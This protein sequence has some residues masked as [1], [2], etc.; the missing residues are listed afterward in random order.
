MRFW[1]SAGLVGSKPDGT[2]A[3]VP[4]DPDG[5]LCVTTA[6]VGGHDQVLTYHAVASAG[7]NAGV[8]KASPGYLW[9][10]SATNATTTGTV[11]LKL[12][13]QATVPV[14][15][16]DT[17]VRTFGVPQGGTRQP[18]LSVGARF[19]VG[20]A[21]AI[22]KNIGDHDATAIGNGDCVVDLVYS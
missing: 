15:A 16:T 4:V 6:P 5:R 17:P 7:L 11:Y 20:I 1:P 10:I 18:S 3:D 12:Y 19:A 9:S 21:L 14:P 13:D 8:L 2:L 22:T